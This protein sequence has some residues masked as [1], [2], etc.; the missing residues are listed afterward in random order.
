MVLADM[1]GSSNL[2]IKRD[3]DINREKGSTPWIVDLLWA[4]AARLGYEKW[5]SMRIIWWARR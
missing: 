3:M 4:T 2:K 5:L 1:I